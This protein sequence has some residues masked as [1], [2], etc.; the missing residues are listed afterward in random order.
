[1]RDRRLPRYRWIGLQ[2]I[3]LAFRLQRLKRP[4]PVCCSYREEL[5]VPIMPHPHLLTMARIF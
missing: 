3:N 5:M 2:G 1:M 4:Y